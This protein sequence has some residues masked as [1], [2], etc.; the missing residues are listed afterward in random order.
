MSVWDDDA[1]ARLFARQIKAAVRRDCGSLYTRLIPRAVEENEDMTILAQAKV[2][3]IMT[4]ELSGISKSELA[5][6]MGVCETEARRILDPHHNSKLNKL[7]SA[8][9]A[10]GRVMVIRVEPVTS[11]EHR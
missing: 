1:E 5:R 4:W 8:L 10:M 3:V 6:R 2:L 9:R 7:E 11:G